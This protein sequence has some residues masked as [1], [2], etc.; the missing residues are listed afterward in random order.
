[1]FKR[2]SEISPLVSYIAQKWGRLKRKPLPKEEAIYNIDSDFA[3]THVRMSIDQVNINFEEIK[4]VRSS[5]QGVS[6][7]Q[8]LFF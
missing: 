3:E 2:I 5:K 6:F 1:M 4:V 8:P 7:L